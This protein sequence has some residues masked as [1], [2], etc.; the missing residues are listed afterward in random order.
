[1]HRRRCPVKIRYSTPSGQ[2]IDAGGCRTRG[3]AAY[4]GCTARFVVVRMIRDILWCTLSTARATRF[5]KKLDGRKHSLTR[6]KD[7]AEER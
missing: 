7:S 6:S 2:N 4:L 3:T 1:M 5:L